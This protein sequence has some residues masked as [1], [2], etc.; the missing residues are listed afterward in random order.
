VSAVAQITKLKQDRAALIEQ[1]RELT[2]VAESEER[3]LTSEEAQEFDRMELEADATEKRAAR[4]EKL[5]GLEPAPEGR[6]INPN[7]DPAEWSGELSDDEKRQL[8]AQSFAARKVDLE[9]Y[10]RQVYAGERPAPTTLAEFNEIRARASGVRPHDEPEYRWAWYRWLTTPDYRNLDL[11]E[12]RV[13]SKASAGAGLNLVPTS[14]ANTLVNALRETGVMRQISTVITTDSG[15]T[16]QI[17]TVTAHGTAAW[18]AE[19]A[20]FSASDETFGQGS[21]SAYKAGTLIKVSEEL[22]QDAAFDL[23]AYIRNEFGLRIGILENTAYVAGDGSGKPTGVATQ[24]SAGVT[25][26][27][28]AAIT[29]DELMD[30]YHSLLSPYRARATWLF[31][32]STIKLIRKLKTGVSGDNTYLWQPGLIAGAPDTLLGRPVYV[33]PDMAAATTGLVSVLF[34]DFSYYWIRDVNGIQFQRLNELYAENGQVGFRAYHRT[35]GKLQ[36]TAAIKKLTQ[37]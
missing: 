32:D 4:L 36:N 26:A 25:A 7:G 8:E 27:G 21:L 22:L 29:A 6:R 35:D 31:K 11:A 15:E 24:A 2:L 16:F 17:P 34:G 14:F 18:V 28:A 3:D 19:N 33:D 5:A 23:E 9:E 1:M 30:L 37:A 10:R 12:T 13:L 20:A